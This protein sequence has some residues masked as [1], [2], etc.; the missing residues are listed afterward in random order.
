MYLTMKEKKINKKPTK[1]LN[2]EINLGESIQ[3][4][5]G[6]LERRGKIVTTKNYNASKVK[7]SFLTM[8]DDETEMDCVEANRRIRK[9]F[10]NLI[11]EI[12]YNIKSILDS[13]KEL[14]ENYVDKGNGKNTFLQKVGII[15]IKKFKETSKPNSFFINFN[16]FHESIDLYKIPYT[17]INEF[18]YYSNALEKNIRTEID[19]FKI[20]DQFYGKKIKLFDQNDNDIIKVFNFSFD[21]FGLFYKEQLTAVI[22]R[23]QEDDKELFIKVKGNKNNYKQYKRKGFF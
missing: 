8:Y 6:F 11:F 15:F 20:I 9:A 10:F 22:N 7:P 18:L 4:L 1:I 12:F 17:F 14:K 21:K 23:E 13:G 16:K 19:F 2:D 3:N 5:W